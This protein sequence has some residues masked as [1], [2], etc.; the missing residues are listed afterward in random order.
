MGRI[1][2]TRTDLAPEG[3]VFVEGELWHARSRNGSVPSNTPVRIVAANG[4]KLV[5]EPETPVAA[6]PEAVEVGA[7]TRKLG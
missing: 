4:L 6:P 5:V 1:A 3:M 7:D 2:H